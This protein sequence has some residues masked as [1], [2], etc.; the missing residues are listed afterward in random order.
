MQFK[1][2]LKPIPA[3]IM[4][5]SLGIVL[6]FGFMHRNRGFL[7]NDP[8]EEKPGKG[9]AR[10]SVQNG[11]TIVTLDRATQM[12]SGIIVAPL[13]AVAHRQ[14]LRAYGMVVGLQNLVDLR[15]KLITLRKNLVD[16][17][18]SYAEAKAR[19]EKARLSLDVSRKEYERLKQL[20]GDNRNI[21]EKAF[22][23][24]EGIW[25]SDQTNTRAAQEASEAAG[26]GVKA[27]EELL[28]ALKDSVRQQWGSVLTNWLFETLPAFERLAQQRDVLIQITL[29]SGERIESIPETVPVQASPGT[30]T[31]AKFISPAPRT[32]PRI[33]GISYFYLAPAQPAGLL[34]GMNVIAHMPVGSEVKGV[35][36]PSSALVWWQGKAWGYKRRDGERFAR[37][38][39]PT[40]ISIDEGYFVSK[41]FE[42]GDEVVV[43]G[44]QLLLSEELLP[45]TQAGKEEDQD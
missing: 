41:G 2:G 3:A 37:R 14:E 6:V 35:I 7:R 8:E 42:A 40:E 36:V 18:N 12:K 44:A 11:E 26:K 43:K 16:L 22:Q 9:T 23:A 13:E 17:R 25:Q 34:A 27:A 38:E 19:L 28:Q 39:V 31:L 5:A 1:Y 32:D 20:Y 4:I 45:P 15:K 10:V 24:Q 21:S 33:Q 30:S 29:P